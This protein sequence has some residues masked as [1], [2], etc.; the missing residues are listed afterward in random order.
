MCSYLDVP[1]DQSDPDTIAG[2][3]EAWLWSAR[4]GFILLDR[5]PLQGVAR[6]LDIGCGTGFPLFALGAAFGPAS[7]VVGLDPWSGAL[8]RAESKRRAYRMS[9]AHLVRANA[10]R[11]PFGD[12]SFDLV[13]SNLGV[14]NFDDPAAAL[15]ECARVLRRKGRIALTTNL[16]GHMQELYEEFRAV[17]DLA[18]S[19]EDV[20]RLEEHIAHRG[21]PKSTRALLEGA[22]FRIEH[23]QRHEFVLRY[24][25][26]SA[27]F[28]HWFIRAGFLPAWR[29]VVG[30][31]DREIIPQVEQRLNA[32]AR[33][34]GELRLT[35]PALYVEAVKP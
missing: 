4:F 23:E 24:A 35:V 34:G 27:L 16:Q 9:Q 21:T 14:N 6:V 8:R 30:S 2:Y 28:S 32:I 15:G 18:G 33:R 26:G 31:R 10:M 5:I 11:M 19:P 3:D 12:A 22:G 13:T 1:V 29:Q 25:D 17:L 7:V 20:R